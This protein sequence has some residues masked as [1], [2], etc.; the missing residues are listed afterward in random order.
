MTHI[1]FYKMRD[2]EPSSRWHLAGRL[3]E[4]ARSLDHTIFI[5]VNDE[6]DATAL[7]QALWGYKPESFLAHTLLKD[8]IASKIQIGWSDLHGEHHDILLQLSD[9][10]P[11]FF[12][13]F[14]R[15]LEVNC[16]HPELLKTSRLHYRYYQDRGYPIKVVELKTLMSKQA[17]G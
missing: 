14:D 1:Q 5:Q 7:S 9:T 6:Q 2:S 11:E 4:K 8:G 3:L 15:V 16:Q 10:I 12:S 13:R 17:H